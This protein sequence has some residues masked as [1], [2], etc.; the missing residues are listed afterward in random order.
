VTTQGNGV[1]R[2]TRLGQHRHEGLGPHPGTGESAMYKEQGGLP[3]FTGRLAG[4]YF[5]AVNFF[6]F[7]HGFL[8]G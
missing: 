4:K 6:S 1:A 7:Y 5:Q 8:W 2:V 3:G